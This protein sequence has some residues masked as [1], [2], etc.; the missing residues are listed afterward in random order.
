MRR[1]G[2]PAPPVVP[3]GRSGVFHKF[4][5]GVDPKAAGVDLGVTQLRDALRKALIAEGCEVVAWQSDPMPAYPV[6]QE[7]RGFG[8]GFPFSAG[9]LDRMRASLE[10]LGR[11]QD[12]FDSILVAG[13]N[14]KGS[15][16]SALA[17]ILQRP[18]HRVGLF[19]SPHLVDYRER[20][21]I[22]AQ[23]V[24]EA[25]LEGRVEADR[26][27]WERHRLTYFEATVALAE[28]VRTSELSLPKSS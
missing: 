3:S 4:R 25:A 7:L 26:E 16:A 22:D 13:T 18:G 15:T 11:P 14:G 6:F 12:R 9:D 23:T 28:F 8:K 27:I 17:S 19:T 2:R 5:V 20:I 1:W 10:D 21:R 24:S